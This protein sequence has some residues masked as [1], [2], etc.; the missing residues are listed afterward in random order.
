MA[1]APEGMQGNAKVVGTERIEVAGKS[2]ECRVIE[3]SG[4]HQG[5]K[6]TGKSWVSEEVP[7]VLVKTLVTSEGPVAAE[8]KME[9]MSVELK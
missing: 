8:I 3:F 7:G 2:Y 4:E 5:N 6:A 1:G 9:L